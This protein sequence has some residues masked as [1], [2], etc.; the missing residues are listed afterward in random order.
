M[1]QKDAEAEK[2][3]LEMVQL[4]RKRNEQKAALDA[5]EIEHKGHMDALK[6]DLHEA[7]KEKK[8]IDSQM[9]DFKGTM[10]KLEKER[11]YYRNKV[12]S[13]RETAAV[14]ED[15]LKRLQNDFK[16]CVHLMHKHDE[17]HS[18]VS[19]QNTFLSR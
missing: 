9:R 8:S 17:E 7:Q 19:G 16:K 18:Q 13:E 5:L 2:L 1:R 14:L 3:K 11:D 12:D 10:R 6:L 15:Q 4:R